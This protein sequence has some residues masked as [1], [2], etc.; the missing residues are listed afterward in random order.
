MASINFNPFSDNWFR[1]PQK[2][3]IPP[4]HLVSSLFKPCSKTHNFA[5]ISN[6]F[7]KK[8]KAEPD[9][10]PGKYTQM[11][12]QFYWECENL[13]DYRHSPEVERILQENP[14]AEKKENP[15]KEEIEENE[16][17]WADFRSNPVVQFLAQCEE[18]SDKLNEIELRKNSAPYKK[19]D[20]KLWQVLQSF[21]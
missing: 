14:Y 5:S 15:T 13:P 20:K 9:D 2:L 10:K 3:P 7:S 19:E 8:P 17:W 11:L 18:I 1:F 12:E 4:I 21:L 6:P 16:K